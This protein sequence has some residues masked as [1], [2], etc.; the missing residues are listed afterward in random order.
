MKKQWKRVVSVV[1][2][3][4]IIILS[5]EQ[6]TKAFAQPDE[7]I[8]SITFQKDVKNVLVE[9]AKKEDLNIESTT[10]TNEAVLST[11]KKTNVEETSYPEDLTDIISSDS[12]DTVK[13]NQTKFTIPD[14]TYQQYFSF[15]HTR[16][17]KGIFSTEGLYFNIPEYWDTEFVYAEIQYDVSQLI[18]DDIP[19]SLTFLLNDEPFSSSN[20]T[21]KDGQT[22]LLYVE[23]PRKLLKVGFNVLNINSYVRIYD[24]EGCSEN[25]STANWINIDK[26]SFI[27]AGYE[28]KKPEHKISYYPYPFISTANPSG[29]GTAILVSDSATNGELSAALYLMADISTETQDDNEI[30][31][32]LYKDATNLNAKNKIIISLTK[33]L[34]EELK[35][36]LKDDMED[37]DVNYKAVDLS[38][39]AMIRFVDDVDGNP[40][41]LIIADKEENLMEAIHM[42]LDKDR[43][44]QEDVSTTFVKE[45]SAKIV[46]ESKMLSQLVAGNYTIKDITGK[47]LTYIGPF[48]NEEILYLPF[49][50]DYVLSSSGK[51]TL[52]F[53]YSQN[54][55]FNRSLMTVFWG[56][57]PI[58]S[59]KLTKENAGNDELIFTMPTDVVGSTASSIKIS[60]DLELQDLFCTMRQ[61]EMPWAYVSEDSVLYLPPQANTSTSFDYMPYPFQSKGIFSDVMVVIS[62]VPD[63]AEMELLGKAIALYGANVSAYGKLKV[64]KASEFSKEDADYNIITAGTYNNNS[65]LKSLNDKLYFQYNEV[66]DAFLSNSKLILADHYAQSTAALQI[67]KSPFAE[68]RALLAI[69]G[70]SNETVELALQFLGSNTKRLELAGDCVLLDKEMKLTN[71]TFIEKISSEGKPTFDEFLEKNKKPVIFTVVSTSGMVMLL[72]ASIIILIRAKKNR[73]KEDNS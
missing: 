18:T 13:S 47:G 56:D 35:P 11:Q 73:K 40:M 12:F 22:Q 64:I 15:D 59:K 69:C 38:N 41:L 34:P 53:R 20:I 49:Q 46:Y 50:N 23:I 68:G 10:V 2:F 36:Y 51:I 44:Q 28:L 57:I 70:T 25:D 16:V 65:F 29:E 26:K 42:L 39:R 4:M 67:L 30:S 3:I 72:T 24:S 66:G 60:F 17:I 55:D 6:N 14:T 1:C 52:K 21:Y 31:L 37:S 48:H 19:A 58:A 5:G 9:T 32:G 27:Y 7:K 8:E 71:F 54:L 43:L 33:N 61:E 63:R 62:D 45:G